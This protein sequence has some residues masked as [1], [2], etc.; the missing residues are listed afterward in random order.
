MKEVAERTVEHETTQQ[1]QGQYSSEAHLDSVT[2]SLAG[3]E[4]AAEESCLGYLYPKK[5]GER[6][7]VKTAEYGSK[8]GRHTNVLDERSRQN[9]LPSA[10]NLESLLYHP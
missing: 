4:L 9:K 1:S 3:P 7:K 2:A 5:I 6:S 10:S 8:L